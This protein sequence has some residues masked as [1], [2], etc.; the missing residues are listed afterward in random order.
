[1]TE[2]G[3]E[4]GGPAAPEETGLRWYQGWTRYMW[5]VLGIAAL[6]WLFDSMDQNIFNLVRQ[7]AVASLSFGSLATGHLTPAQQAQVGYTSGVV[8]AIFLVGWATGGLIFGVIGDRLGR[9]R[10]M[11]VTILIYACFTGLSG[12]AHSLAVF[13]LCRF[14]TALGVGGE[15]AAGASI[16]AEVFPQRSR[17]MA[18]GALGALSAFGNMIAATITLVLGSNPHLTE[19]WRL[20]FMV[21]FLPALLVIWIQ[22]SVHEPE[23]WVKAKEAAASSH[24]ELGAMLDLF[25]DP[26]IRRNTLAAVLMAAAGVGGLWGVGFWTPELTKLALKPLNLSTNAMLQHKSCVFLVQQA[27]AF[28]GMFAYAAFSERTNRRK[29]LLV[30][31]LL[32]FAAIQ[33]MFWTADSFLSLMLWAPVL[34]FCTLGPFSAYGIYFPELFPTRLRATGCGFCYNCARILAALAPFALGRMQ[35]TFEPLHPGYGFRIATS[36]VACVY[37]LGLVGLAFAPETRGRPLPE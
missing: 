9:V 2:T 5:I 30:F 8:T 34:G 7:D 10:T 28:C 37:V 31:F 18:L 1:M 4:A 12:L 33:G 32:S 13:S 16:V 17:A 14:L 23:R 22:R 20:A 27:G 25:R 26:T 36:I 11:M 21:G 35:A 29:S 24:Q 6:G 15:W 19:P 3:T